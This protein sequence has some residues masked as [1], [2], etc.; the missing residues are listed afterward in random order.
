[1]NEADIVD[2]VA[3]LVDDLR[4]ERSLRQAAEFKLD[5]LREPGRDAHLR[6]LGIADALTRLDNLRAA[7]LN[8]DTDP[9][10]AGRLK[11]INEARAA[12]EALLPAGV[13]A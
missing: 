11:G 3:N 6:M 1:M 4:H 13:D 10:G 7:Y 8:T 12:L 5:A 2:A 9:Y